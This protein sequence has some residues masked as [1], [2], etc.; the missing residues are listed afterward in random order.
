MKKCCYR[1]Q[2]DLFGFVFTQQFER[3]MAAN[4]V[5][6]GGSFYLQSKFYRANELLQEYIAEQQKATGATEV[7]VKPPDEDDNNNNNSRQ[8]A[9]QTQSDSDR[10][11]KQ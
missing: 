8:D 1:F 7:P 2:T 5:K 10:Q 6:K 4:D 11:Q 9:S 3:Y